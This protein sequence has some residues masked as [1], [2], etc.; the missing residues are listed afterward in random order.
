VADNEI[1]EPVGPVANMAGIDQDVAT[2]MKQRRF[3]DET[4]FNKMWHAL[5]DSM[6][7]GK[8]RD[9]IQ[10]RFEEAEDV[11]LLTAREKVLEIVKTVEKRLAELPAEERLV[12]EKAYDEF[13]RINN[14][15]N[16]A[17]GPALSQALAEVQA[18]LPKFLDTLEEHFQDDVMETTDAMYAKTMT[19]LREDQTK[20]NDLE[21]HL[22]ETTEGANCEKHHKGV[23]HAAWVDQAG[24]SINAL[25]ARIKQAQFTNIVFA[26]EAYVSQGAIAHIVAGMQASTPEK[27]AKVLEEIKPAELLQSTNE[28]MADF[29]KDMKTLE[30]E[31][32]A[33]KAGTEQRRANG[34]AFVHASK[35]LSR[36]LNAAAMLQDKYKGND[37]ALKLLNSQPFDLCVRAGVAGPRELQDRVDTQLVRLRKSSTLPGDAKA[38]VAVGEV[39]AMFGVADIGG[40]RN[41]ITAFGVDFNLRVRQLADF[42][43][44]QEVSREAE[45]EYFRP[46]R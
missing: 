21:T 8:D 36:M 45:R 44:A 11:Y 32:K 12:F 24:A 6:P 37:A 20:V 10:Q 27:K 14:A 34:E 19:A 43:A 4:S 25:K 26:N 3:L 46:A 15:A 40:L 33:K 13:K 9:R 29:Y 35:Y 39:Q 23:P 41:L 42:S 31:A 16:T 22:L 28:Q 30:S 17:T 38:E 18:A 2:L 7:A 5:R 1:A